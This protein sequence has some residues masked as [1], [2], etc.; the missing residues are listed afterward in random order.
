M[1]KKIII[2]SGKGG[3]GKSTASAAIGTILNNM[4]KKT[5]L[6]DCDAALS[7]LDIMLTQ[8]ERAVFSWVDAAKGSCELQQAILKSDTAPHLLPAPRKRTDEMNDIDFRE[9]FTEV[10]NDYDYIIFDSPAGLGSGFKRAARAA[11]FGVCIATADEICVKDAAAVHNAL[12]ANGVK[13]NRLLINKYSIPMAKKG[14]LLTVDE[15]I[16][17]TFIQLIGI[18]PLDKSLPYSGLTEF[19]KK[20]NKAYR[21]FERIAKRFDGQNVELLIKLIK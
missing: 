5:L 15:I 20:K 21:A 18:V 11:D 6:V 4:G 2:T 7:S 12:I 17:T 3:V 14:K 1:S 10:E 13:K 9:L 8:S 19:F 16:D